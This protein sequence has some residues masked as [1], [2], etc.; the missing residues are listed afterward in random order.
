[1]NKFFSVIYYFAFCLLLVGCSEN[2]NSTNNKV[3]IN[4]GDINVEIMP[5]D[6]IGSG[7]E[8]RNN[9]FEFAEFLPL[10]ILFSEKYYYI[11]Q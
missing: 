11:C 8:F 3:V 4:K 2:S 9:V 5:S 7:K 6:D 10:S 1:M